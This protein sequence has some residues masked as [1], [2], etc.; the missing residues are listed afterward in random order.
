MLSETQSRESWRHCQGQ[1]NNYNYFRDYDPAIGRYVESDPIGLK[2]GLNTYAYVK[3][4]PIAQVDPFGLC[5]C[6]GGEWKQ[7]LGDSTLSVAFGG[8]ASVGRVN[9]ICRSRPS[10]KCSATQVCIGGGPIVGGGLE[11]ALYGREYGITDSGGFRGWSGWNLAWGAGPFSGSANVPGPGASVSAGI[12]V[13]GGIGLVRCIN[14]YLE[15][16]C[17]CEQ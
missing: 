4:N 13:K 15:C 2:G 8:Y 3:D 9:Y 17:E 6:P 1:P 7:E 14:L 10:T 11:W 16:S 5:S 12:S